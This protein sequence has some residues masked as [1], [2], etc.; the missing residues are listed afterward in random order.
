M[1]GQNKGP[2]KIYIFFL[3]VFF[4][5]KKGTVVMMGTAWS[6]LIARVKATWTHGIVS[7]VT[8]SISVTYN[9][10]MLI[11]M[12]L[13]CYAARYVYREHEA[14][15]KTVGCGQELPTPPIAR[16]NLQRQNHEVKTRIPAGQVNNNNNGHV[17]LSISCLGNV[18]VWVLDNQLSGAKL[19]KNI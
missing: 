17:Q 8:F 19:K 11:E 5:R 13:L 7:Q 10:L 18:T 15:E 12:L 4:F 2:A 3:L 16:I 6:G 14:E 9:A 1:A